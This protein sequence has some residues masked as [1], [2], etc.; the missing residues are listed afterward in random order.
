MT[1]EP[2]FVA[3]N[4]EGMNETDKLVSNLLAASIDYM[5]FTA[6]SNPTGYKKMNG[7]DVEI[8]SCNSMKEVA[9]SVGFPRKRIELV[10]GH[11]FPD[12]ILKECNYGVEIKSTQKDS[13]TSTGSSIVESSRSEEA[14]RIYMLF[15]KLGGTPEFMCKPYQQCLSNIAVTHAPR[16]LIDMKLK[17]K[18]NIFSK[19]HTEYD[20]FRKL[21][22]AEKISKVRKYYIAKAKAEGKYEM[23]WWMG[24][25][26][27]VNLTFYSNLTK[28]EKQELKARAFI[29]FSSIFNESS[30]LNKFKNLALWLCTTYSVLNSN[31]RDMF[32]AGGTIKFVNNKK[33]SAPYP[34]VVGELLKYNGLIRMLLKNPDEIL[35]DNIHEF[36]D[37]EFNENNL[38]DSWTGMIE[39]KFKSLDSLKY[40]PIRKLLYEDAIDNR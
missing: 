34:H 23:P 2:R 30:D 33:L 26:T 17:N 6:L 8:L 4:L 12:I 16:Y 32:S 5:N 9:P 35:M 13:W 14:G 10:S 38:Y 7:S 20:K 24:E 22:E 31:M 27:S 1:Q 25:A 21:P 29:L 11:T 3:F 36:W 39:R 28:A 37:F 19:M 18:D 40:I 15:G